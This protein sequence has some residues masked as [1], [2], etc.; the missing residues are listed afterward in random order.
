[1]TVDSD[2][3]R[4]ADMLWKPS[5][6]YSATTTGLDYD[7]HSCSALWHNHV[8]AAVLH[9]QLPARLARGKIRVPGTGH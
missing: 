6:V 3:V 1:M 9:E 8:D 5:R 7:L 4:Y 2:D